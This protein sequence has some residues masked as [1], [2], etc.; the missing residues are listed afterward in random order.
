MFGMT[1]RTTSV[2]R[3]PTG[4][5]GDPAPAR[6]RCAALIVIASVFAAVGACGA[7][8]ALANGSP[9]VAYGGETSQHLQAYFLLSPTHRTIKDVVLVWQPACHFGDS[10]EVNAE[11]GTVHVRPDGSFAKTARNTEEGDRPSW[12]DYWVEQISGRVRDDRIT[13]TFHG[14]VTTRRSDGKLVDDCDSLYVTFK[15]IQ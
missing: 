15:A 13:G 7:A 4:A 12:S 11:L 8:P 10:F 3:A 14:H 2:W 6:R 5:R 1:G 9:G